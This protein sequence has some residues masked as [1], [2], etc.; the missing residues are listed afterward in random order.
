MYARRATA[1]NGLKPGQTIQYNKDN[2]TYVLTNEDGTTVPNVLILK[3]QTSEKTA[4]FDLAEGE[5]LQANS[6]G[7]YFIADAS[8]GSIPI[9]AAESVT[10]TDGLYQ[11]TATD[12]F[13]GKTV[14]Y[15]SGGD[16][17]ISADED[18]SAYVYGSAAKG[19]KKTAIIA[20]IGQIDDARTAAQQVTAQMAQ[21]VVTSEVDDYTIGRP[22][23]TVVGEFKKGD[24]ITLY[25][26]LTDDTTT[27]NMQV[28]FN[29]LNSDVFEQ[30]YDILSKSVLQ[31]DYKDDTHLSGTINVQNDGVFYTSI[32][33]E[34][35]WSVKIDG[36]PLVTAEEYKKAKG[37]E[38]S[39]EV[40]P[41]DGLIYPVGDA[42]LAFP[43]TKGEHKIEISYVPNGFV[44]G[45]TLTIIGIIGL[46]IMVILRQRM[47]KKAFF[48]V[49]LRPLSEDDLPPESE[50]E[51]KPESNA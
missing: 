34:K 50:N 18:K 13:T 7:S 28:Y 26:T 5:S 45:L 30:G 24:V 48:K 4:V 41:I 3:N 38:E 10:E 43:I 40:A 6:D 36:E 29:R 2:E 21:A 51:E 15:T 33:Y 17:M 46:I 47:R 31:A 11:I 27:G 1:E 9:I 20:N 22:N 16:M 8:G 39:M 19:G 23:I 49:H 25:A 42:L 14:T 37:L 35:G 44:P 32:P 12:V